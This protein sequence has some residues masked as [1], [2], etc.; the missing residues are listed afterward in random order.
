MQ[1]IDAQIHEPH[2]GGG[3]VAAHP[4][5]GKLSPEMEL[6]VNVELAREAIDCVGVDK[7]LVYARQEFNE[8]AVERYP[9]LFGAVQVFDY[10]APDLEQ[11]IAAFKAKPGMVACRV[12]LTN[13]SQVWRDPKAELKANPLIEKGAFDRYWALAAK[14]KLPMFFGAHSF[15]SKA[16]IAAERHPD[17]TIIID[18]FGITQSMQFPP[19]DR[20]GALPGLLSLAK[21]PNVYVKLCGTPVI[22][23]QPY[24][25]S[26]VWPYIHQ[27]LKAFGPERCMW[28][29][30]F[31]RMRWG[32]ETPVD[33]SGFPPRSDWISYAESLYYMLHSNEISQSDKEHIFNGT[34]RR[35]LNFG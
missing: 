8:A 31:T 32:T 18:H 9:N 20:W 12:L 33:K 14:Y 2:I 34:V 26:N 30:D 25:Y 7:A 24:P 1:I 29:S 28:A 11:Q 3:L 21:Y 22:S 6:F 16:S 19:K 13:Y 5:S 35:A 10:A 4:P 17:L 23:K 15:A 27:I